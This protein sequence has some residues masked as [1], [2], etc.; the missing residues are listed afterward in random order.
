MDRK[1]VILEDRWHRKILNAYWIV[2]LMFLTA[3]AVFLLSGG[4][5][6]DTVGKDASSWT[7]L[8][9]SNGCTMLILVATEVWLRYWPK[10]H[11]KAIVGCGFLLSYMFYFIIEPSADGAQMALL[12]PVLISIVYFDRKMLYGFGVFTILIY[13]FLYFLM[14]RPWYHKPIQEFIQIESVF[15]VSLIIGRTIL[16][17]V[18]EF[19]SYL[20]SVMKSEQQLLVEKTISDKLLKMDALTGLYNHKTFHEYLDA[21]L[22]HSE[23]Y[24]LPLQLAIIDIDG[25]KKV[26]DTYGHWVGDLVLKQVASTITLIMMPNDFA[27]RYGGEE[28]AVIFADKTLAEAQSITEELRKGISIVEHSNMKGRPVTVSIGLC[29]YQPGDDKES[30]FRKADSALYQAKRTGKNKVVTASDSILSDSLEGKV[31]SI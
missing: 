8:A 6:P 9:G 16:V 11:K 10:H 28:F 14:E 27:S 19:I 26:N 17:R 1:N 21:L 4:V 5:F 30:L 24:H 20:K 25:F 13:G 2:M 3:Q 18:K 29:D 23:K 12:L 22:E 7:R 31:A 15:I